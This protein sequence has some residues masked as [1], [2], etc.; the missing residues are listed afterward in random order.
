M[1]Y[2]IWCEECRGTG[3]FTKGLSNHCNDCKGK[4]Y[5]EKDLYPIDSLDDYE[6]YQAWREKIKYERA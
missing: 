2:K 3:V 6:Q 5:T 4:G 1:K